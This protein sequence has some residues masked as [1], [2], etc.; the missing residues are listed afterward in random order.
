MPGW[1]TAVSNSAR[2]VGESGIICM[3]VPISGELA[4]GGDRSRGAEVSG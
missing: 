2:C 3:A 4:A 1:V